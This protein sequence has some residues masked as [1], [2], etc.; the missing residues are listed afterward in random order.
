MSPLALEGLTQAD[1]GL[2]LGVIITVA[3]AGFRHGFDIDH[4]AAIADITSVQR[5]P[6]TTFFLATTYAVGHMAVVFVL[7]VG[8]VIAG[9]RI[10]ATLDSFMG[11]MIGLTLVAL[12]LYVVYSLIRYRG[13]LRFKSRW[14]LVLAGARR[15]LIW[16]R[17][18][19]EVVIEHAHEHATDG[20][21][22]HAPHPGNTAA[23][24][25]I[26][27]ATLTTTHTH[28]H[29]HVVPM[30]SDPFTEY[31]TKTSLVI[32]MIHGVGVETPTQILLFT[33]AA[34]VAGATS[35]IL[36]V[37]V[38]VVALLLGNTVLALLSMAGF[39][40]GKKMPVIY[41]SLGAATAAASIYVGIAYLTDRLEML[42]SFLA[43]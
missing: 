5:D 27:V 41:M 42:P 37:A 23:H 29:T 1:G 26:K 3:L 12:G 35:G 34:G 40:A 31:S 15:A 32:G 43:G 11:R 33:T 39:A 4:I 22:E 14:M 8:A 21:H 38:F 18:S 17:P 24:G 19:S 13:D 6:K 9:S 16:L 36:L 20:H 2:A 25:H 28:T 30:P 10:P 7:G